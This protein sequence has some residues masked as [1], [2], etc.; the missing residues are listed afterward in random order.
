MGALKTFGFVLCAALGST[1]VHA[2]DLSNLGTPLSPEQIAE[3]NIDVF[4][5]GTGLPEGEGTVLAGEKIYGTTCLVCHGANLEGG[6]GSRLAGGED[7]LTS[8]KP[9]KTIGSYWP[10]ATT[11]FDYVRRTMPFDSPQSMSNEEVYSVVAYLLHKNDILPVDATLDAES[12]TAIEMP[13]YGNFYKDERPDA[14]NERCMSDCLN[15]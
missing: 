9:L 14:S 2:Y 13:N 1:A 3:W 7:S 5:D 11:L 8:E 15:Q 6:L 10:Y 4:P 12:L